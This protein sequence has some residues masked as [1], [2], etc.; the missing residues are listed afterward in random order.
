[1]KYNMCN[2]FNN[3]YIENKAETSSRLPFQTSVILYDVTK[4]YCVAAFTSRNTGDIMGIAISSGPEC[5]VIKLGIN[6]KFCFKP[7][8]K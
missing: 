3:C 6:I 5:D 7:S 4:I 2:I 8:I 1:M